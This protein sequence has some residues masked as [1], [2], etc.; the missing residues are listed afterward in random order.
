MV[1]GWGV[2]GIMSSGAKKVF[3]VDFP[4]ERRHVAQ[5]LR[6][7]EEIKGCARL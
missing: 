6:L 7:I 4:N 2:G 3:Q 5:K 1:S